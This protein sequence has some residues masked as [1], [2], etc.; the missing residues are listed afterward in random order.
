LET[1]V[2]AGPVRDLILKLLSIGAEGAIEYTV[3]KVVEGP[4]PR[5]WAVSS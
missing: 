2:D 1:V 4:D 5:A 3:N